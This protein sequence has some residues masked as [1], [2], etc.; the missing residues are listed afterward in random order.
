VR[1]VR[2]RT[3]LAAQRYQGVGFGVKE[4]VRIGEWFWAVGG[5]AN[6]ILVGKC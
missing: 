5:G 4:L 3:E 2:A 1:G 6:E